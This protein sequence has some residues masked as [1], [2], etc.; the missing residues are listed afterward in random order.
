MD[1][2]KQCVNAAMNHEC[3]PTRK[4]VKR[5]MYTF[6]NTCVVVVI[7]VVVIVVV[8]FLV[9]CIFTCLRLVKILVP[10]PLVQ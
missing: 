10:C 1:V 6:N 7:V 2:H 8:F 3:Q 9:G 4:F 5:G